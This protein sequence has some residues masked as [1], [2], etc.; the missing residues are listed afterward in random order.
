MNADTNT[1]IAESADTIVNNNNA[2]H[3]ELTFN[4]NFTLGTILDQQVQDT[5]DL[6]IG[7]KE[8][9]DRIVYINDRFALLE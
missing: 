4:G 3:N 6:K 7:L 1:A 5:D 2:N 9:Y 8:I